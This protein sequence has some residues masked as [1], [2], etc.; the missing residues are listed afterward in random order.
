VRV[1]IDPEKDF[2]DVDRSNNVWERETE[3]GDRSGHRK[4]EGRNRGT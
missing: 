2:A 4:A 1:E 3:S